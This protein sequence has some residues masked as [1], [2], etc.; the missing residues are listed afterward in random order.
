MPG[1]I[2]THTHS[3]SVL[4]RGLADDMFLHEWLTQHMWPAEKHLTEELTYTGS[5]LGYLEYLSNGMTTNVDMWYFADAISKAA[6]ESGLRTVIAPGIFSFATPQS[7]QSLQDAADY[8]AHFYSQPKD[9]LRT[10]RLYP[11]V[12]PHDVYSTTPELLK[13]CVSLSKQYDTMIHMHIS[14]TQRDNDEVF[15]LYHMSPSRVAEEAGVFERPT[16][17]AHCVCLSDDDMNIFHQYN[18]SVSYNPVTNL[19]LCEGILPIRKLNEHGVNIS[20]GVDGAQSNNSLNLVSDAKTGILIQ[21]IAEKDPCTMNAI[22]TI[23]MMTINGAKAIGMEQYIGSLEPGKRA[24]IISIDITTP[25]MTPILRT[26]TENISSLI[27]YTNTQVNDVLV[28]GEFLMKNKEYCRIDARSVMQ[29]AQKAA[30]RIIRE[31]DNT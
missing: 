17:F 11:C 3:P 22:D 12:G 16:L 1:M 28:D 21:K 23:R 13:E 2:N 19:K 26:T 14:E 25:S 6:S 31:I 20:I 15:S 18:A 7:D 4:F 30:T 27:V 5:R 29:E 8:L 10:T 24:D 9:T